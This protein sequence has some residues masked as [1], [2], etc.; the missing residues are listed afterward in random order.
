MA[1]IAWSANG[2]GKR[3]SDALAAGAQAVTLM[4]AAEISLISP[5]L[6]NGIL[7]WRL[8]EA[9]ELTTFKRWPNRFR[10]GRSWQGGLHEVL[11]CVS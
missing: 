7:R 9:R 3:V 1:A 8:T 10:D 4:T 5:S 6:I 2:A 11:L